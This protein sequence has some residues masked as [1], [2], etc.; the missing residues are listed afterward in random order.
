[1]EKGEYTN[2]Y[3]VDTIENE[4]IAYAVRHYI[5]GEYFKD[6]ETA[7]LWSEADEA[8]TK[9]VNYLQNE[10]GREIDNA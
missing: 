1:M 5:G 2:G 9:L 7:K 3:A 4:G 8:L 6:P 10:T